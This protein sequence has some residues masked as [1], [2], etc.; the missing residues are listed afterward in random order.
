[1]KK[2]LERN[3]LMILI[4]L[5]LFV[6]WEVACSWGQVPSYILPKPS[7]IFR[8]LGQNIGPLLE[9]SGVTLV[10]SLIG[11]TI[12][13]ALAVFLALFMDLNQTLRQTLHSLLVISQCIPSLVLAPL[14]MIWLGFG[15]APKIVVVVLMCFYPITVNFAEGLQ[16]LNQDSLDLLQSFGASQVQIYRVAKIPAAIPYLFSG[17]R[18]AATYSISAAVIGEWLSSQAGL[19]YYMIR[20]S[21][22]YQLD[23]VFACLFL[24]IFWSLV[25]NGLVALFRMLAEPGRGLVARKRQQNAQRALRGKQP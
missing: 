9:H 17:L 14:L 2:F 11:I 7:K 6:L 23:K 21:N 22:A 19:G 8:T 18:V 12:S 16:K 5:G 1:M 24:I 3:L 13:V 15:M 4:L 20:V 10:E 25:M